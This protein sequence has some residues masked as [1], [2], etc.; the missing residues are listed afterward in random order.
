[1][2]RCR[3]WLCS[4]YVV[5][6]VV[7]VGVEAE[8]GVSLDGTA[9]VLP[10]TSDRGAIITLALF[11]LL[12]IAV[13]VAGNAAIATITRQNKRKNIINPGIEVFILFFN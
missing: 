6:V 5:G 2:Y 9:I 10:L 12:F 1:M 7:G 13:G 3:S 4:F 11:V 8:V